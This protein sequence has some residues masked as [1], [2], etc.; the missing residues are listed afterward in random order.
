[1]AAFLDKE[2][3]DRKEQAINTAKAFGFDIQP[4]DVNISGVQWEIA[5]DNYT[6]I[7]PLNSIK[8][9]GDKAIEQLIEH[10]PFDNVEDLLFH[11]EVVYS[12][13]NKKALDVLCRSQ[14]LDCL[15]DERFTGAKHFWSTVVVDRPKN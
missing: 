11:E 10:R 14:A 8:G 3:E 5:E 12:K 1:M 7:Q 4:L 2:P 9:L 6:L 13:L 15:I